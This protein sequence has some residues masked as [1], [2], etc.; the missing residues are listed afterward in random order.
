M[1]LKKA[2]RS[3]HNCTG[4]V[5]VSDSFFPFPDAPGLLVAYGIKMILTTT[6]S[7][8]DQQMFEACK[9][10]VLYTYPDSVARGFYAH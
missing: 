6:G 1:A 5:A 4:A 7:L 9:D 2:S 8:N 10:I 3:V